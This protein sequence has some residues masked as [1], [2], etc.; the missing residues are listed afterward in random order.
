M[1]TKREH[2]IT[3]QLVVGVLFVVISGAIF[4]SSAWEYIP[5]FVKQGI[6]AMS[7]IG[8]FAGPGNS[9]SL[10]GK[11]AQGKSCEFVYIW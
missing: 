9:G 7:S 2:M 4:V 6:V 5:A 3:L 1:S 8:C 10:Q 11:S